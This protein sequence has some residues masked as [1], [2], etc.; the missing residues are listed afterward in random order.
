MTS[1]ET[2][3]QIQWLQQCHLLNENVTDTFVLK[4]FTLRSEDWR[5]N[6]FVTWARVRATNSL[7]CSGHSWLKYHVLN[8]S[9][10]LDKTGELVILPAG[11][12]QWFV[13]PFQSSNPCI[14]MFI[15]ARQCCF[16]ELGLKEENNDSSDAG[17]EGQTAGL[18]IGESANKHLC[19][20]GKKILPLLVFYFSQCKE[21]IWCFVWLF[22]TLPFYDCFLWI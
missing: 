10:T 16:R 1:T 12:P 4:R 2:N 5:I 18:G 7:V 15:N 20:L 21:F 9:F 3:A 19:D 8:V 13:K 17:C 14:L 6:S 22:L 11:L